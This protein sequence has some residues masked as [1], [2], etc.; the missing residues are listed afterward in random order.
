MMA[1]LPTEITVR[2]IAKGGKFLGAD[3]GGAL[4][5]VRNAETGELLATGATQGGS[6]DTIGIMR[7]SRERGVPIPTD[8][9]ASFSATLDLSEPTQVEISAYGPLAGLQSAHRVAVTQW[10]MPGKHVTG[11][12]GV[13]L[14]IPGLLV[15]VLEPAT[16]LS[17]QPGQTVSLRANVAMMCGCPIEPRG[18]WDSSNFEVR[19]WIRQGGSILRE[20]TLEYAGTPSQFAGSWTVP[21]PLPGPRFYEALIY[22]YE[23]RSGNTGVGRV[24]F[25]YLPG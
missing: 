5:W 17:V 20:V 1:P 19:A 8:D 7:T 15:Q 3:I 23:S 18:I 16:H 6:G 24:T 14:E 21:E 25:F 12:E 9:A 2:V 11:G 4:V 10:L 13:L 22:A